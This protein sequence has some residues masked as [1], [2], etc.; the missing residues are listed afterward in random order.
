MLGSALIGNSV[1]AATDY[2]LAPFP[3]PSISNS[4]TMSGRFLVQKLIL[5]TSQTISGLNLIGTVSGGATSMN[6]TLCKGFSGI[7]N[8]TQG[9][10][11]STVSCAGNTFIASSTC[12]TPIGTF[13]N[14]GT[15]TF[16][17]SYFL[18]AGEYY[19]S[20]SDTNLYGVSLTATHLYTD[21]YEGN[22]ANLWKYENGVWKDNWNSY[23]GDMFFKLF[24]DN[25]IPPL[26]EN[27]TQN[28]AGN[29]GYDYTLSLDEPDINYVE[30]LS[31][32]SGESCKLWV[33]FNHY[34]NGGKLYLLHA[35]ATSTPAYA[36]A[37]TTLDRNTGFGNWNYFEMSGYAS[38]TYQTL[39]VKSGNWYFNGNFNLSFLGVDYFNNLFDRYNQ[40]H[41]CDDVATSTGFFDDFRYG[42]ECGIRKVGVWALVPSPAGVNL[43]NQELT[44]LNG[45][46]P[47]SVYNQ[48]KNA[49][50]NMYAST[51]TVAALPIRISTDSGLDSLNDLDLLPLKDYDAQS[52]MYPLVSKIREIFVFIIWVFMFVYFLYR[53]ISLSRQGEEEV[54]S[55]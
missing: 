39:L 53:I 34:A 44:K 50:N 49:L 1:V 52:V 14:Y 12:A 45:N 26:D 19:L 35:D 32:V 16:S 5:N 42:V 6:I 7:I 38:G 47:L 11:T 20:F 10:G 41:I 18:E 46:F 27:I 28:N 22:N 55:Q 31:C 40:D 15:C 48:F 51:S 3:S 30:N 37:S 54:L 29:F 17:A 2:W 33:S 4:G 9:Y 36:I 13:P 21:Y 8:N 23:K 43:M 25:S 24:S